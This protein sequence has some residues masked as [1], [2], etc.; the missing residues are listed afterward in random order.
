VEATCD[1]V[2]NTGTST[3]V[4]SCAEN[5]VATGGGFGVPPGILGFGTVIASQ[6][7]GTPPTEWF[8]Q[9]THSLDVEEGRSFKAYAVCVQG[10]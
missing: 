9:V 10:G 1:I 3:C 4:A 7:V 8:V 2:V 5:E 6:P